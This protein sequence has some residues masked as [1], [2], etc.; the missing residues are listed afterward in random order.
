MAGWGST[1]VMCADYGRG[2]SSRPLFFILVMEALNGLF[3]RAD[4]N[5]LLSPLRAPSIKFRLSLYADDLVIFL[6]LEE[7]DIRLA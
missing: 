2:A 1:S 3:H 4:L 7:K 6:L 5:D